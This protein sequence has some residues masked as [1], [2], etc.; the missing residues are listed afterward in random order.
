MPGDRCRIALGSEYCGGGVLSLDAIRDPTV[1]F[2]LGF[3]AGQP[4][5]RS[6]GLEWRLAPM[7]IN[8]A[9]VDP[10]GLGSHE[11]P[12]VAWINDAKAVRS[13]AMIFWPVPVLLA[14][15]G[16]VLWRRGRRAAA[17][18][19]RNFCAGCGYDLSA[20]PVGRP[21]PECGRGR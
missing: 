10:G 14:I 5:Q 9:M 20:T 15:P 12:G 17:R 16:V 8:P 21:C 18:A 2:M 7:R 4:R 6:W 13:G 19:R 3:R 1:T 11:L